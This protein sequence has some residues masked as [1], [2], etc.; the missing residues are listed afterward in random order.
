M[1]QIGKIENYYGGLYVQE[2]DGKFY[3][4]IENWDGISFQDI[5]KELYDALVK[6][7]DERNRVL[8]L[9]QI[10]KASTNENSL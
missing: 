6:Y 4:G 10:T 2:K 5:P 7:E 9:S 1:K 8:E 3:W